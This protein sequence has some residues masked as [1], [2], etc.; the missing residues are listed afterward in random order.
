MLHPW[1]VDIDIEWVIALIVFAVDYA[2]VTVVMERRGQHV[3]TWKRVRSP[4]A[5]R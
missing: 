5:S 3:P 1:R 2:V 4:P